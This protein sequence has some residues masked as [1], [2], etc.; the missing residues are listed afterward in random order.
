M[1]EWYDHGEW[2]HLFASTCEVLKMTQQRA[3]R[4]WPRRGA[5]AAAPT[6]H[7]SAQQ[8]WAFAH[9]AQG[10]ETS[11]ILPE[12]SLVG[13]IPLPGDV[14]RQTVPVKHM[15][16]VHGNRHAAGT[17]PSR[18]LTAWIGREAAVCRPVWMTWQST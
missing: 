17:G 4:A 11:G 3:A 7:Q 9:G 5:L 13:Q 18:D 12:S 14:S 15:P 8:R 1:D 16:L 2:Q 6:E 10:F